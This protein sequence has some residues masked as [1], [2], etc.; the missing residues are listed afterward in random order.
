[1]CTEDL[2]IPN[3]PTQISELFCRNEAHLLPAPAQVEDGDHMLTAS[4]QTPDCLEPGG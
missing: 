1:M 4:S 3:N 2:V